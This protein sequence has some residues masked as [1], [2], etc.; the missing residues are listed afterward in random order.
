MNA[1]FAA[2]LMSLCAP[3]ALAHPMGNFSVSHYSRL[4]VSPAGCRVTYVLD[5]AE[6]PTFELL[7]QWKALDAEPGVIKRKANA[8]A[9]EWIANLDLVYNGKAAA[10]RI[11][12]I[13]SEV[14]E[15]AGGMPIL[16]VSAELDVPVAPG[17][18]R[19]VD[20]NYAGRA[21]WKEIV[22]AA[23]NGAAISKAS[24]GDRD[25]TAGLSAY[26]EDQT[27]APP[28][29]VEAF[30][31]WTAPAMPAPMVSRLR[32]PETAPAPAQVKPPEVDQPAPRT[33]STQQPASSGTV[34][35]GDY[36]SRLLR[37]GELGVPLIALGMLA[38]FGLGMMHALAPGHGKTIVAAYLVGSR[39]TLKHALFLGSMVTFT[40]TVSVFLLGLGVLFFQQYVVPE[41]V[42]PVLGA[43][44]GASI[45][46]IGA[47]L[48]FRRLRALAGLGAS[49]HEHPH[50][51]FDHVHDP[52]QIDS[53]TRFLPDGYSHGQSHAGGFA[54][55]HDGRTHTHL[56]PDQ[57]V[58]LG[59]LVAL[60][61]SGGLVPCPSALILMLSA[62]ALGRT[63][64]GLLLL[65]AFS[66][67]L[68]MVLMA[69]GGMVLYARQLLPDA[70][71]LR[72]RPFFKLVP[73]FS[74]VVVMILGMLMT[75]TSLG[76]I[77]P[78][79]MLG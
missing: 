51:N 79:R 38:A 56:L 74:A 61:V 55:T 24:H 42:I 18:L 31:T 41:R 71:S 67:G 59:S 33:F 37:R 49:G 46:V 28:Q 60:G 9:R 25:L 23:G 22:I 15:G 16:R 11:H 53:E 76:W 70:S 19:Y 69:I 3:V 62:I 32:K 26:P 43:I 39:G 54:H 75:M 35:S 8:K 44:S 58:S 4:D 52:S 47:N 77:T 50:Y 78:G 45:V 30:V 12:R 48:F 17:T 27:I 68:A 6:I 7:Q 13:W 72:S 73:V 2:A 63:S 40:H 20:R 14:Y 65:V 1:R 29:D 21:G 64:F 5:L 34:Q 10:P 57:R 66:L 36:L